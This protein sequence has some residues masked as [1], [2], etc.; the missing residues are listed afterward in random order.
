MS[1]SDVR[2]KQRFHNYEKS[3]HFLE[4]AMN[5]AQ[6]DIIQKAGL[7]Q[8]F[9]IGFE[10]AWNTM[11]DYL[12]DQGFEGLRSPRDTIK[13]G[14]EIGLIDKGHEWL[15]LLQDRNNTS[16]TY[17]EKTT[18]QITLQIRARY[19]PLLKELLTTLEKRR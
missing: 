5:I 16:H 6:P 18:E 8:F 4:Q 14:F 7:I 2:W 1:R 11:K 9:E 15:Q 12:E 10:L 3:L 17:D 19:Y 13:K